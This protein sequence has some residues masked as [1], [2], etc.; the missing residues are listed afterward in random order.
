MK[1]QEP[2]ASKASKA[3]ARHASTASTIPLYREDSVTSYNSGSPE[4]GVKY[5]NGVLPPIEEQPPATP[6]PNG[7][8]PPRRQVKKV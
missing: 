1:S 7:R 4:P 8:L 2:K 5:H 6:M 3:A